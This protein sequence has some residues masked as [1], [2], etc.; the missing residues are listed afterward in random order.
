MKG[1]LIAATKFEIE[2]C[3]KALKGND[4]W[5][6]VITGIGGVVTAYAI[7]KAIEKYKP[8]FMLQAGIAGSFDQQIQLGDVVIAGSDFFGDLGVVENKKRK[9][10]FDLNL[11]SADKSPFK[12]GRLLNPN[13]K[14][15][16]ISGRPVVHAV[17]V[18]EI[19]TAKADISYYKKEL[20]VAV[21]SMEGAAFHYTALKE[22]IP[23]LQI[24]SISNYVG[25]R[26]KKKWNIQQAI[27]N[28]N[29]EVLKL[30]H[31]IT[32]EA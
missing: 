20:E 24:R 31:K 15:V 18:N 19:T 12:N 4:D 13:K 14:L 27:V 25:V 21:E 2:P 29:Y 23:F 7:L 6:V 11:E 30:I 26:D 28:L 3:F 5:Q 16:K 8:D 1:L 22:K 10:I 9:T 17:S 32:N